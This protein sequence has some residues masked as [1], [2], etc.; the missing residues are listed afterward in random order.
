MKCKISNPV[1]QVEISKKKTNK[2]P[3]KLKQ[4]KFHEDAPKTE[5]VIF[6]LIRYHRLDDV[7]RLMEKTKI[8]VKIKRNF[9][10]SALNS[11]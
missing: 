9:G 11:I 3:H 1:V 2:K 7:Y 6:N 4:R 10:R 8:N 5:Q